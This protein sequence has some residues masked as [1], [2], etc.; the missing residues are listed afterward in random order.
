VRDWYEIKGSNLGR[1]GACG[2]CGAAIAGRFGER[3][4]NFGRRRVRLVMS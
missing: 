4:G 3:V 1:D 2:S